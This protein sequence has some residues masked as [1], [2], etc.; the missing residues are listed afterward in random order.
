MLKIEH[1]D[2]LFLESDTPRQKKD[3]EHIAGLNLCK[4][5]ISKYFGEENPEFS[6]NDFGKPYV[7]KDGIFFNISHSKGRVAC[8][9]SDT[10][11]GLDIEKVT[12]K[13]D[14]DIKNF[15]KRYFVENEIFALEREN[16]SSVAFYEIWTRKEAYSKM[17][18]SALSK[19]FKID[20]TALD[21]VTYV[22]DGYVWS[23]ANK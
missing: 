18:G 14:T 2:V 21:I 17:L 1:V 22:N 3:R 13:N 19:N 5:M 9:V 20:T 11:V 10:P 15:A 7:N 4:E 8:A 12:E 23:I 16:Y 6:V